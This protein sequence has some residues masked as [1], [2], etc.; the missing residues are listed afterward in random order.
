MMELKGR[1]HAAEDVEDMTADLALII[2]SSAYGDAQE[3]YPWSWQ[4]VTSNGNF[5]MFEK[6]IYAFWRIIKL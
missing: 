6:E 3:G 2:R 5:G 4:I 1:L